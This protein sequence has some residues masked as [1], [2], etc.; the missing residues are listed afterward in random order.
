[1][2]DYYMHHV[3]PFSPWV[4]TL[5]TYFSS[6][7]AFRSPSYPSLCHSEQHEEYNIFLKSGRLR[8]TSAKNVSKISHGNKAISPNAL[9]IA[10]RNWRSVM[11]EVLNMSPLQSPVCYA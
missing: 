2:S 1:M 6:W 7:L 11:W 3:R 10:H 8:F 9:V 4:L 5:D